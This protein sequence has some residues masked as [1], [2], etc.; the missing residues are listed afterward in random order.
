M[1]GHSER[2]GASFRDP[3][4]FIF[5][6]DGVL[7]RQV[8]KA[9]QKAYDKLM[10]GGVYDTLTIK[11]MLIPHEEV[12]EPAADPALAYKVIRP[13]MVPF[14]SYPYEW[15]FSQLKDAAL[16]TLAMHPRRAGKRG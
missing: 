11:G 2:I 9:Y 8:N 12:E 15:S 4:G 6:R 7:Y 5:K 14:V 1:S 16:L 3:S 10:A 13:E